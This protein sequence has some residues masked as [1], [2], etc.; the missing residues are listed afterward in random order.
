[1]KDKRNDYKLVFNIPYHPNFFNLKDTM[2]L[3]HLLLTPDQEHQQ[4]FDNVPILVTEE[5]KKDIL[6]RAKV[7]PVL[8]NEGFCGSCKKSRCEICEHI[9][10]TDSFKSIMT[11]RTYFIRPPDLECS[12]ENVV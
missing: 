10:S 8:K 4:V 11:Q 9:V 5:W 7:L 2:S 1:M 12:S 3:L 6:V